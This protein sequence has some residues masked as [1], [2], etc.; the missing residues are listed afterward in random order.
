M[1]S[2]R[3]FLQVT[4]EEKTSLTCD[5]CGKHFSSQNAQQDHLRSK[6]HKENE[7]KMEKASLKK[8]NKKNH[9]KSEVK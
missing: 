1:L 2:N 7:A 8:N 3:T 6:K 9:A 5:L 4:S